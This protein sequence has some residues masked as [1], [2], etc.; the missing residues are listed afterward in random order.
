M[1]SEWT[2]VGIEEV[3]R[4]IVVVAVVHRNSII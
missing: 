4:L 2:R 1:K 3:R